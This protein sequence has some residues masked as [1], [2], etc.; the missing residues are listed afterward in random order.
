[1]G[2]MAVHAPRSHLTATSALESSGLILRLRAR[3]AGPRLDARLAAGESPAADAVLE[4]R[5][6]QLL[7]R[8]RRRQAAQGL[9][10]AWSERSRRA[11]FSAAI[12]V[13][14]AAVTVARP[15]LEQLA[16]ALRSR[17]PVQPRGVALAQALLS[18]PESALYRPTH[19]EELY[20]AAR[21]ALLALGLDGRDGSASGPDA[22]SLFR[23]G[24]GGGR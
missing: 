6:L 14:T 9:A 13:D 22:I 1:M 7:S 23:T 3:L 20:E 12:P 2:E 15:A 16:A 18:D 19:L 24:I 5:S 17:R 21:E 11:G 4:R 8:R 10:R